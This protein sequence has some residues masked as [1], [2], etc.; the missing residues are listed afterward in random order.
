MSTF[1]AFEDFL[2]PLGD[3]I[4]D[5]QNTFETALTTY[6]WQT[7]KR[8]LVPIAYPT[9]SLANYSNAFN[10]NMTGGAYAGG[11]SGIG[12]GI[13]GIQ[14]QSNFT[15]TV[16]YITS[17]PTGTQAPNTFVLE[18]SN[19]GSSWTTLQTWSNQT[20]WYAS[21]QRKFTVIGASGYAYWRLRVSSANSTILTIANWSLED[22]LKNRITNVNFLDIIPPVTETIG[23]SNTMEVLR[24]TITGTTLSLSSLQYLKTYTPQVIALWES[25]A[26]AVYGSITLNGSTING[27]TGA[28]TNTAKQNLRALYESIRASSDPNFTSWTWEYQTPSPQNADDSSDYIYGTANTATNWIVMSTNANIGGITIAGPCPSAMPQPT[29]L[30]DTSNTT[31]QIDL[32][33]GFIYYLQICSRGIGL[34]T[35]TNSGFY[36]PVHAC[37]ANNTEM[38][39]TMPSNNFGLPLTPIELLIGWDDVATNSSSFA[40]TCHAWAISNGTSKGI[41]NVAGST[42]T[43]DAT[44]GTVFGYSRIRDKVL[45]YFFHASYYENATTSL[46]GSGIFTGANNVGNDYQIHRVNCVGETLGSTDGSIVPIVPALDIQDWYKFVGSATDEALLLVADTLTNSTATVNILTSDTEIAA[47]S[48]TGFATSGYIVIEGE[49]IQYSALSG[50]TFVGCTRAMYGT[51]ATKHFS[52]D[53]ISQGL[54]FTKI[55]GGALLCGYQKPS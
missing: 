53:L 43:Y 47:V 28:S 14:L 54:W 29:N 17:S 46:F 1:L 22:N 23:N 10:L 15:P 55:N 42:Y 49:I 3:A 36:G 11:T 52:N 2:I 45:D 51:T 12:S 39:A 48:T 32:I 20:N 16:M 19:D 9:S 37:Y 26:G 31:L 33:S 34:A 25:V 21:E 40:R 7:Q 41:P 4:I 50:N 5:V 18:Y 8:A 44:W 13:I 35:K 38:L 30:F 24:F 6:G 27:P